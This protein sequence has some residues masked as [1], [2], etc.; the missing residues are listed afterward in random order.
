MNAID[1]NILIYSV[2]FDEVTKQPI[3][4]QLCNQLGQQS[5]T[6]L[7]WQ[8]LLEFLRWLVAEENANRLT[9]AEVRRFI[10]TSRQTFPLE[11]PTPACLDRALDLADR[12]QLSHWDSMLVAAGLEA[13]VDTLYTEDMGAPRKID[14]LELINPFATLS[15]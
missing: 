15:A 13:G 8:A 5:D 4:A 9:R 14:S 10:S 1:T 12:H 7:L 3:A 6:L 2:D 11:M